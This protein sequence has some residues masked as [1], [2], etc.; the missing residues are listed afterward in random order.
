MSR[1][2]SPARTLRRLRRLAAWRLSGRDDLLR[3]YHAVRGSGFF[4]AGFYLAA[5]PDVRRSGD[6]PLLHYVEHG[7]HERRDPSALVPAG[8]ENVILAPPERLLPP[9]KL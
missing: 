1:V 2:T 6:D 3:R 4:D 9:D 8:F 7:T 5:N